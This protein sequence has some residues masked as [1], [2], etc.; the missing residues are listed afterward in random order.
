MSAPEAGV[1]NVKESPEREI[2]TPDPEGLLRLGRYLR[3]T[4]YAHIAVTPLTHEYHNRRPGNGEAR[5]LRDVLGWSLPFARTAVSAL[6][7]DLL[8]EAKVLIPEKAE[9][10]LWRSTVRWASLQGRLRDHVCAHSAY[11]TLDEDAVFF[12][13]DT[14]RFA[15]MIR[16]ALERDPA[17]AARVGRAADIGTGSGAGALMVADACPAAR[18]FALDINSKALRLARVNAELAEDA[19]QDRIEVAR[20][21]LLR[22]VEGGFDLIVANPPYMLDA[23][24]RAYRH[25]GGDLGEGLS[26]RIVDAALERLNPGG[27][28]LLYTGVAIVDGRDPLRDYVQ[29]LDPG[30]C[31]WSYEEM[32]PDV[33][34]DELLKPAYAEVERIAAVALTLR[35]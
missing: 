21:N 12:G 8:S 22:D 19:V 29:K 28:L 30:R 23:T 11:P 24:E 1:E 15:R 25:G 9:G 4:G 34:S 2:P 6:E 5:T 35:V 13:P 20:S 17:F 32:D 26:L 16:D 31:E 14:Y 3:Q 7:F 33:F 10:D 27:R 18:V